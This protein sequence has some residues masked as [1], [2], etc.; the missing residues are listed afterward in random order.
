MKTEVRNILSVFDQATPNEKTYGLDWYF[1]ANETA[2]EI[3]KE[4]SLPVPTVAGVIA[5]LSPNQTFDTTLRA[6]RDVLS[7]VTRGL[8]P[9]EI[10]IPAYTRNKEKAWALAQ[11]GD[12]ETYLRGLKVNAFYKNIVSPWT[13]TAV[14][15]DGHAYSV[16]LGDRVSTHKVPSKIFRPKWFG[17]ISEDY[18]EASRLLTLKPWQVQAVTWVTWRR[19]NGVN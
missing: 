13:S 18:V 17:T 10:T 9:Y 1:Q 12:R 7:A 16:W 4:F 11:G 15:V 19:L 5:V 6:A 2:R 14:T 8:E 3:A